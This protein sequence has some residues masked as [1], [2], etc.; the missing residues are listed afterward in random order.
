MKQPFPPWVRSDEKSIVAENEDGFTTKMQDLQSDEAEELLTECQLRSQYWRGFKPSEISTL[1]E[2]IAFLH[3]GEGEYL[4]RR[5]EQACFF[6][7]YLKGNAKVLS[8]DG[9]KIGE[10][11]SGDIFGEATFFLGG[12]RGADIVTK[13]RENLIAIFPF[14]DFALLY[15]HVP[16]IASK[17][18]EVL[19]W[20]HMCRL[21]NVKVKSAPSAKIEN[22]IATTKKQEQDMYPDL[23][24]KAVEA[25]ASLSLSSEEIDEALPH[26]TIARYKT[27]TTVFQ[28]GS[29]ANFAL[30]VLAGTVEENDSSY[31]RTRDLAAGQFTS[32]CCLLSGNLGRCNRS[33]ACRVLPPQLSFGMP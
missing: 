20:T 23:F 18:I 17:T 9:K 33:I 22:T 25:N 16:K 27:R 6:G 2:K 14:Q 19:A 12:Y 15:N 5:R 30:F 13:T 32:E 11:N 24:R 8:E 28:N 10:L 31:K 3:L 4:A 7:I 21:K 26:F 29:L 1:A